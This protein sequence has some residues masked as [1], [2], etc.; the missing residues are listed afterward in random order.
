MK[1]ENSMVKQVF[2]RIFFRTVKLLILAVFLS[3]ALSHASD[4][5]LLSLDE[6]LDLEVTS[7]TKVPEKATDTPAAIYVI[8]QEDLRRN[9]IQTI[10]EALRMVPGMHVYQIDANKWA[11][12]ARGFSSR[13]ANKML[14]MID[15]RTVYSP[16]FSGVYWDVQDVMLEDIDRIEVIR[17]PGGTLWGANAVNGVINIISKDSADTQGGLVALQG[18]TEQSG[19]VSTRY[20][21]WLNDKTSYRL[22]GKYF[23]RG[24]FEFPSGADAADDYHSGRGGFR[25]D[26]NVSSSNKVTFQGDLY[27]GKSGEAVKF[28]TPIPPFENISTS[29]ANV[30]GGNLLARWTRTFSKKSEVIF[31]AYYDHNDREEF[32]GS[33][34]VDTADIDFQHRFSIIDRLEILWGLGYRHTRSNMVGKETIHGIASF[35]VDPQVRGDDLY[36]GFLQG[37]IPFF[38][39]KGEFTLGTKLEHNDYSGFEWQ[40]SARVMYHLNADH[41]L[42]A[43]VSRTV[44]TPSRTEHDA[45]ISGGGTILPEEQGGFLSFV[46]ILG[47]REIESETI[48]SYEAGYRGRLGENIFLDFTVYYNEYKDLVA[49]DQIAPPQVEQSLSGVT[50]VFPFLLNNAMDGETYGAEMSCGW[51]ITDWW[52]LTGGLTWFEFNSLNVGN[53]QESRMGFREDENADYFVSLVSY[54]DLPE[55]FEINTT[56]YSVDALKG[57]DIDS[58]VRLDLNVGWHPTESL[59]VMLGARNLFNDDNQEFSDTM[60]GIQASNI[61]QTFYTKISFTF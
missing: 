8:T 50:V 53:S 46:R 25:M 5:E 7:A 30:S 37:R 47:N 6:L 43:A 61:P 58:R 44:R 49:G 18:E 23:N 9:S 20:G 60:D 38:N 29:D 59:T 16:L 24:H 31:Q 13:F 42:W 36:S 11:V 40:P 2:D 55:N 35:S 33:E 14:V 15:G 39:K 34:T 19:E 21:G 48:A 1:V 3:P 22:Y 12:S 45:D 52:R 27:D 4:L 54:M 32:F 28:F 10:P 17:G 26:M 56:L 51:S 57:L 41:S